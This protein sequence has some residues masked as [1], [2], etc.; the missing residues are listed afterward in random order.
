MAPG[1]VCPGKEAYKPV[2]ILAYYS[3]DPFHCSWYGITLAANNYVD[4]S[5]KGRV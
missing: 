1:P 2:T 5:N 4:L 3:S